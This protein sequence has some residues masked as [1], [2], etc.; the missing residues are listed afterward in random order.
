[1]LFRDMVRLAGRMK[2]AL[3]TGLLMPS[4]E[5]KMTE[6]N[7]FVKM[8]KERFTPEG[9]LYSELE[10]SCG[11]VAPVAFTA[12]A[13]GVDNVLR[14]SFERNPL[15]VRADGMDEVRVYAF[16]PALQ[17]GLLSASVFRRDRR[18]AMALPDEWAGMEVHFYGFVTDAHGNASNTLYISLREASEAQPEEPAA[19]STWHRAEVSDSGSAFQDSIQKESPHG[20]GAGV[21]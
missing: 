19:V 6:C 3:R 15:H 5:E 4:M 2:V 17:Q 10:I 7:L 13:V 18:L 14:V 9:V 16:C 8:N 20:G 1:M 21:G 12:A 11:T